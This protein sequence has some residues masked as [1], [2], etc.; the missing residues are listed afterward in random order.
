[1]P[2]L[3]ILIIGAHPDDADLRAGGTASKWCRDGH[4]VCLLSMTDGSAGHHV[5]RGAALAERRRNEAR[6]AAAVIGAT[7]EVFNYPD[8]ELQPDLPARQRLIRFIRTFHPDLILTHRPYD[9]HPDNRYSAILVQD[10]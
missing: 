1:M 6:A 7:Y 5:F 8:G 10:A 3:R 9:Y 4:Q 2:R